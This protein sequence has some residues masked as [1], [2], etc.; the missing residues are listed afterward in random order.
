VQR[1]SFRALIFL[2]MQSDYVAVTSRPAVEPFCRSG[3]LTMI[4]LQLRL[5]PMVQ[6]LLSSATRPLA[7]NA[8]LL[9]REFRKARRAFKR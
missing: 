9:A 3:M 2:L 7:P 6:Y 1:D 5:A 4:P 8:E